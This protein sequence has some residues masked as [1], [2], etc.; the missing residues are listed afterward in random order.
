MVDILDSK[1]DSK[2]RGPKMRFAVTDNPG[3]VTAL[4][5]GGIL[6]GKLLP[7][8]PVLQGLLGNGFGLFVVLW[9]THRDGKGWRSVV[10]ETKSPWWTLAGVAYGVIAF[11]LAPFWTR[12]VPDPIDFF[13]PHGWINGANRFLAYTV[14]IACGLSEE[15]F[16]RGYLMSRF[17]A[18]EPKKAVISSAAWFS[19]L[20]LY[21]PAWPQLFF[22][23][24]VYGFL[25]LRSGSILPSLLA[26]ALYNVL[27]LTSWRG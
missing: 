27:V 1:S 3:I 6:A 5:M 18:E 2:H 11:A 7:V 20:H 25:R 10:G 22:D 24:L 13:S 12:L 4:F 9:L 21:P 17:S 16:F 14:V 8:E 19:I 15:V 26:H 23:G